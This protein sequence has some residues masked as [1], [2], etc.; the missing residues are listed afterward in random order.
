MAQLSSLHPAF[1]MPASDPPP[2]T[3][4]SNLHSPVPVLACYGVQLNSDIVTTFYYMPFPLYFDWFKSLPWTTKLLIGIG[5][6]WLL[7]TSWPIVVA[8]LFAAVVWSTIRSPQAR[9]VLVVAMLLPALGMEGLWAKSLL[10]GVVQD[11]ESVESPTEAVAKVDFNN[12]VQGSQAV[13]TP[14]VRVLKAVSGDTLDVDQNGKPY[15]IRLIGLD[16]PDP[17]ASGT[18][19]ECFAVESQMFLNSLLQNRTISVVTDEELGEEDDDGSLWRYVRMSDGTK[20]NEL[21]LEAGLAREGGAEIYDQQDI[22]VELAASSKQNNKG[23]WATCADNG[24]PKVTPAPTPVSSAT[25]SATPAS[26]VSTPT[27]VPVVT[28]VENAP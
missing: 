23:L 22:F 17:N 26:Q 18:V 4:T 1:C 21:M 11:P 27:G 25:P 9:M 28:P 5:A 12:Q 10:A 24:K 16:A 6:V 3:P 2:R 13:Q 7:V 14:Q 8:G 15:R 19:S 20:V